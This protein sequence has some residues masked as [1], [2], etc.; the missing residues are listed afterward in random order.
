MHIDNTLTVVVTL[1]LLLIAFSLVIA[2]DDAYLRK[3]NIS[4]GEMLLLTTYNV[5]RLTFH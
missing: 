4:D 2:A 5:N 3:R 1:V